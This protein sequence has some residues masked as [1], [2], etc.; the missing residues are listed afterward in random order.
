MY[1]QHLG[2]L[3]PDPQKYAD[4]RTRIQG[5]K[6]QSKTVNKKLL[7]LKFLLLK[8]EILSKCFLSLNGLSSLSI[9]TS[10]KKTKKFHLKIFLL[11]KNSENLIEICMTWI[12]IHFFNCG[13]RIRIRIKIKWI[14]STAYINIQII[15]VEC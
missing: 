11:L 1:P 7:K 8:K 5:V 14:P 13:F 4:P 15:S 3:D 9:K 12:R 10:E 2:F 6:Y